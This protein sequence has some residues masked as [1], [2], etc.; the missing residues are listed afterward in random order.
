[1][2]KSA[3]KKKGPARTKVSTKEKTAGELKKE[4]DKTQAI[5]DKKNLDQIKFKTKNNA[6]KQIADK[7]GLAR[8]PDEAAVAAKKKSNMI[9]QEKRMAQMGKMRVVK[10]DSD[11]MRG[12]FLVDP[13]P[14]YIIIQ[15]LCHC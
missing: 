1:M 5:R 8:L 3:P 6:Y 12:S 2:P 4:H 14:H 13:V 7:A 15:L 10:V 11:Q 9:S